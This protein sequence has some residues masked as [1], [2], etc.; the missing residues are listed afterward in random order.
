[1]RVTTGKWL[2]TLVAA[3]LLTGSLLTLSG[4]QSSPAPAPTQASKAAA[5]AEPTKAAAPAAATTAPAAAPTKAAAKID[6]PTKAVEFVVHTSPGDGIDLML[7]TAQDIINKEKMVSQTINVIN[8]TGGSGATAMGYIAS[9]ANDPHFLVSTQP[10]GIT[11]PLR[12]K[13]DVSY[14]DFTPIAMMMSESSVIVVR[15]ESPL[16]SMADLIAAAKKAPKSVSM[17]SG[18]MGAADTVLG[19]LVAK[20]TGVEFN[21]IPSPDGGGAN[22]V[23]LLGGNVDFIVTN[24]SEA[25]GQLEAK[26]VRVLAI[27]SAKRSPELPDVPTLK[28]QGIDVEF[29]S[30][31][32]IMGTKGMSPEIVAYWEGV[33]EKVTKTPAWAKYLKDSVVMDTFMKHEDL[34]KYLDNQQKMYTNVLGD[35]GLLKN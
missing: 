3:S 6:Y 27:S 22:M 19:H 21:V 4:C 28:E 8:K 17:G 5:A 1:M 32:G 14:K 25:V 23:K 11:T 30:F 7:R 35:M 2:A 24:P 29:D 34:S 15:N 31:R 13:M 9:K 20:A 12:N 10:S 16:K 18:V 33:F 26:K